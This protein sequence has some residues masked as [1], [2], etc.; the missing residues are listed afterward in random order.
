MFHNF[1]N[2]LKLSD[3]TLHPFIILLFNILIFISVLSI[4]FEIYLRKFLPNET[5]KIYN[6]ISINILFYIILSFL[7]HIFYLFKFY[8]FFLS[9]ILVL[10]IIIIGCLCLLKNIK[11]IKLYKI[12]IYKNHYLI[13]LFLYLLISLSPPT[14]IDSIDYHLGA[15]LEWFRNNA[16]YPRYDWLHYKAYGFGEFI[17][18]FGLHFGSDNFGQLMQFSGLLVVLLSSYQFFD[19]KQFSF[20]SLLVLSSPLLLFLVSTQ[21]YQLFCS[22]LIFFSFI[23]LLLSLKRFN[24]FYLLTSIAIFAFCISNKINYLI[25]SIIL[26]IIWMILSWKNNKFKE[27]IQFSFIIL[28]LIFPFYYMKYY[29]YGDPVPPLFEAIKSNSDPVIINFLNAEKN[30]NYVDNDNFFTKFLKLFFTTNFGDISRVI[31]IGF[32]PLLFIKYKK[33]NNLEKKLLLF[34]SLLFLSYL[35]LFLGIGRYYLD[36]YFILSFLLALLYYRI[37]YIKFINYLLNLQFLFITIC[38][39]YGVINLFPGSL[40]NNLNVKIKTINSEGYDLSIKV[41]KTLPVDSK[42]LILNFRSYSYLPYNFVSGQ[43]LSFVSEDNY[44]NNLSKI[45]LDYKITHVISKSPSFNNICIDN[46]FIN[47]I[48]TNSASRNP[49]NARSKKVYYIHKIKK[50]INCSDL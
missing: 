5:I 42:I 12:K 19:K 41:D 46:N 32:L 48:E 34:A 43:Y 44:N 35:F 29:F 6:I 7:F 18:L 24:S 3:V 2:F 14:D 22:S 9:K 33:I 45:I 36:I 39:I 17:N 50:I 28:V 13:L 26:F 1:H 27:L 4:S 37:H 31:G 21:K 11:L 49:Y 20:F 25:P 10:F 16:L 47:K 15:P 23:L 8:P 30:F 40:S 38:V